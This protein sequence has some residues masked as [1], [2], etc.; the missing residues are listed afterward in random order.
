VRLRVALALA[1]ALVVI[2]AVPGVAQPDV[3]QP[4]R[5]PA[6][7]S[8]RSSL[9]AE[10]DRYLSTRRVA[11]HVSAVSMA[12][13][14]RGRRPSINLA[15]G[16]TRYRGGRAISLKHLWEIGSNTKAFTAVM[17]LQ[18]EAEGKLSI[19][20]TLA[21]WLPQYPA[22]R[23]ITIKQL[24]NMT[25]GIQDA[26][27]QPAFLRTYDA[28]PNQVFSAKRLV[29]YVAG[30]PLKAGWTYSNTNYVLAQM[31]IERVTHERY[32]DQLR[33][34]IAAPLGLRNLF[35]S[36][37][38]YP[39]SVIARLP[40]GYYYLGPAALPEMSSQFAKDQSRYPVA[41]PASG[42]IASSPGALV[43]W[44]RAL[45]AGRL[46]PRKQQRELQSLVSTGTGKPIEKTT[47]ADPAGFGLGISQSTVPGL[48][49]VWAYQGSTWGFRFLLTFVPRSRTAIAISA[50]S[51][52]EQ[53]HLFRLL[54]PIYR[55][56]H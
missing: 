38:R 40:A 31:I 51:L 5:S 55:K 45:F 35:F 48:G 4:D 2:G 22:W 24:L 10:L 36:A 15:V 47:P 11:E 14:F 25:S 6:A 27:A 37:T 23:H 41:A 9:R 42:G 43:K 49:T 1:A 18:L 17:M 21:K 34:R 52:P 54:T 28:A 3:A 20:D 12:V 16:S 26:L 13:A 30:L 39:R 56:L 8:L 32:A 53:D 44:Y 33:K 46:L 50:N 19:D 7:S 29:S